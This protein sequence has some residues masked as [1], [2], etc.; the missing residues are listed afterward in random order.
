MFTLWESN[1]SEKPPWDV[2]LLS[3]PSSNLIFVTA[4]ASSFDNFANYK[5]M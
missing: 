1:L 2:F 3:D 5:K 4:F